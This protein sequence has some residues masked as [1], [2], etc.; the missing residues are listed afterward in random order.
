MHPHHDH[1]HEH[2]HWGPPRPRMVRGARAGWFGP[3][4]EGPGDVDDEGHQVYGPR[5]G[6]PWVGRFGPGPAVWARGGGRGRGGPGGGRRARRGDVRS[7]ILA[8]LS[9]RPMHGYEIIT[10]LS[11][12]TEGFWQPSPG[13]IYPT[14]Q[15]LEDEGFVKAEADGEGGRRRFSLTEEGQRAATE[16]KAG[17]LPWEQFTAG[18][19]AGARAL[20]RTARSLIAVVGQVA[21]AGGP[22]E[23]EQTVR[24]LEE[25]RRQ[26]YAVLAAQRPSEHQAGQPGQGGQTG[27]GGQP[28]PSWGSSEGNQA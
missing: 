22:E 28:G 21:M 8:L 4:W 14:L 10:E 3:P 11:Q 24:I 15:L 17:P 13:S 20:R 7:A 27:Q 16:A 1:E 5:M 23:H 6:P 19:P 12:R 2:E 25:A 18:A 26:L 9:E